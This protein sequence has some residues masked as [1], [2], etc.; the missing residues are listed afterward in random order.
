MTRWVSGPRS[1]GRAH[2]V[3]GVGPCGWHVAKKTSIEVKTRVADEQT[4]V[5]CRSE[6]GISSFLGHPQTRR[7]F[8]FRGTAS[9]VS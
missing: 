9:D 5:L 8:S 4:Y 6:Q 7:F 1:A 3:Q 2:Q